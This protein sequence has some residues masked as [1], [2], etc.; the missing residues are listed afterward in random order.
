[1]KITLHTA[2]LALLVT[3]VNLSCTK[4][5]ELV[6]RDCY[7]SNISTTTIGA[8]TSTAYT[9]DADFHV[10]S[11]VSTTTGGS[12]SEVVTTTYTYDAAGDVTAASTNSSLSGNSNSTYVYDIAHNLIQ[13]DHF[14]NGIHLDNYFYVY[15]STLQLTSVQYTIFI[16]AGTSV[17][18][19]SYQYATPVSRNPTKATSSG[20]TW[21]FQYDMKPN[22]LKVLFV[23]TQPDNN[24]TKVTFS[25]VGGPTTQIAYTYQYDTNGFPVSSISTDGVTKTFSYNCK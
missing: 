21:E 4:S 15:N 18:T 1:M 8:A 17:T 6:I 13:A 19:T 23:S 12:S 11:S 3:V 22:P 24:V 5:V 25:N 14:K 9:Y 20:S 7:P 16:G 10:I 2:F